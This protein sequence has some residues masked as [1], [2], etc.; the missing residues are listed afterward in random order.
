MALPALV[1]LIYTSEYR[2][3]RVTA[4]LDPW[5]DPLGSGDTE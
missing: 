5:S 3:R 4:F 1:V 2:M